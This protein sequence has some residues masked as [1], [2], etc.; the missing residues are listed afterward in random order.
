VINLVK[1]SVCHKNTKKHR[2]SLC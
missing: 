1:S 2:F